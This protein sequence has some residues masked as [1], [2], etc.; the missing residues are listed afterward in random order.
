VLEEVPP[1]LDLPEGDEIEQAVS[2]SLFGDSLGELGGHAPTGVS[3][4]SADVDEEQSQVFRGDTLDDLIELGGED[5]QCEANA[6]HCSPVE[7]DDR[8]ART[9]SQPPA[10][11]DE[12][13]FVSDVFNE[14]EGDATAPIERDT[15]NTTAEQTTNDQTLPVD[16]PAETKGTLFDQAA[17]AVRKLMQLK[18]KAAQ[19]NA[20]PDE[21][22]ADFPDEKIG[23]ER[24][25]D[26]ETAVDGDGKEDESDSCEPADENEEEVPLHIRMEATE[27]LAAARLQANR[28]EGGQEN[29]QC[30]PA[31]S[32]REV[33]P[34]VDHDSSA[35]RLWER[36]FQQV[37]AALLR[38]IFRAHNSS[39]VVM[40]ESI[41]SENW[42]RREHVHFVNAMLRTY[43]VKDPKLWG[44][45]NPSLPRPP[46]AKVADQ[47]AAYRQLLQNLHRKF[48]PEA[49]EDESIIDDP[50]ADLPL[51]HDDKDAQIELGKRFWV[52]FLKLVDLV[53]SR[54]M[55]AQRI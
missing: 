33:A 21:P 25:I 48:V 45:F 44:C 19:P 41:V 37:E 29:L 38:D 31:H 12:T 6:V 20:C 2:S 54:R 43:I 51:A 18:L 9:S 27:K 23:T 35:R 10:V 26:S 52:R 14:A 36:V 3:E 39:K 13:N 22:V 42:R 24:P 11:S 16:E 7:A 1:G 49:A 15:S 47:E 34:S 46:E 30:S 17:S 40:V 28:S 32:D 4:A 8:N 5:E 55:N 53:V 50:S